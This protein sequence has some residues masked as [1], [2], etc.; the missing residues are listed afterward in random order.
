AP[1]KVRSI[2]FSPQASLKPRL[3]TA[4]FLKTVVISR[5]ICCKI[6]R[7]VRQPKRAT[8]R[9]LCIMKWDAQPEHHLSGL[10][11]CALVPSANP[12]LKHLVVLFPEMTWSERRAFLLDQAARTR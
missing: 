5:I 4:S 8:I 2:T 3:Y 11:T 7:R 6:R 9:A 10:V 12:T 1:T